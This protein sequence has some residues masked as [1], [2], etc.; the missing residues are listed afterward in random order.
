MG[1]PG[2]SYSKLA[3][4]DWWELTEAIG[5][6]RKITEFGLAFL[7]GA[8]S[9]REYVIRQNKRVIGYEGKVIYITDVAPYEESA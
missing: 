9:I 4:M 3:K 7:R 1:L 2:P 6:R 8:V 5:R